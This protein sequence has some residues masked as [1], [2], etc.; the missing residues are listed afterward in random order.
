[1]PVEQVL[2]HQPARP[3]PHVTQ[4]QGAAEVHFNAEFAAVPRGDVLERGAHSGAPAPDDG[5]QVEVVVRLLDAARPDHSALPAAVPAPER[6]RHETR[7]QRVFSFRGQTL[8]GGAQPGVERLGAVS[9][10]DHFPAFSLSPARKPDL[11]PIAP[12]R[13]RTG[14]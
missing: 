14:E 13:R 10:V 5:E 6:Q 8:Q 2:P 3:S 12:A 9:G 1:M 4:C 11:R 7:A